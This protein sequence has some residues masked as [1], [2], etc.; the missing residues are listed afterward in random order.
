VLLLD[1][2]AAGLNPAETDELGELIG[3]IRNL[4]VTV[5]II[6]HH[7]DMIMNI[8]DTVTVLDYGKKIAEGLPTEVRKSDAVIEAYLGSGKVGKHHAGN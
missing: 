5:L 7:L 8:C 2:P 1:E 4:G 6:E 3:K